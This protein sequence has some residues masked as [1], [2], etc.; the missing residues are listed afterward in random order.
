MVHPSD[1]FS[2]EMRWFWQTLKKRSTVEHV[3]AVV[4][5]FPQKI[6]PPNIDIEPFST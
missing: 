2:I 1:Y 3:K 6:T 4:W 5:L